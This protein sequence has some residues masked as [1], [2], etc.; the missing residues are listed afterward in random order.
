MTNPISINTF[1]F[2]GLFQSFRFLQVA[3]SVQTLKI[4]RPYVLS[5]GLAPALVYCI[6]L[7]LS[8]WASITHLAMYS[9]FLGIQLRTMLKLLPV[10]TRKPTFTD[11]LGFPP[12]VFFGF[13]CIIHNQRMLR[14]TPPPH[15]HLKDSFLI[16][17]IYN[18]WFHGLSMGVSNRPM[19]LMSMY[20]IYRWVMPFF[21]TG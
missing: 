20:S 9:F 15:S 1:G 3:F 16:V 13:A 10:I 17:I 21:V 14:F 8:F 4:D 18:P 19:P 5:R 12:T 7:A 11:S 6:S 2:I